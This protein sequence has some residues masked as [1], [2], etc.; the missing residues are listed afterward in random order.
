VVRV[1]FTYI[2][3]ML[4]RYGEIMDNKSRLI[5][6]VEQDGTMMSGDVEVSK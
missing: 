4:Y 6:K 5:K 1:V 3:S 2:V